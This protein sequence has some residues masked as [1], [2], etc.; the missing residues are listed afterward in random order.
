M[1]SP[2]IPPLLNT[3][4]DKVLYDKVLLDNIPES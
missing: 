1:N 3:L 4:Y 2:V